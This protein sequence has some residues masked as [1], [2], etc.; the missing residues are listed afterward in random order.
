MSRVRRRESAPLQLFTKRRSTTESAYRESLARFTRFRE[1]ERIHRLSMGANEVAAYHSISNEPH[2][3]SGES[4]TPTDQRHMHYVPST[5]PP[6]PYHTQDISGN[7]NGMPHHDGHR[8]K[9][10]SVQFH[11]NG[12]SD[13]SDLNINYGKSRHSIATYGHRNA[14][15]SADSRTIHEEEIEQFE[16]AH[17]MYS[18]SAN[19]SDEQTGYHSPP[20]KF[21]KQN[22]DPYPSTSEA[23]SLGTLC[24]P[25]PPLRGKCPE[26][27]K[28]L[29]L[30]SKQSRKMLTE[31]HFTGAYRNFEIQSPYYSDSSSV[32][33]RND[34][35][36]NHE[37]INA[38]NFDRQRYQVIA[39]QN[40]DEVEYALPCT[41]DLPVFQRGQTLPNCFTSDDSILA[42]EIF[43]E[44]PQECE[45]ILNENI[46]VT[47]NASFS[48][49][50]RVNA[51]YRDH[52]GSGHIMIT[53]LDISTNT[54]NSQI[55]LTMCSNESAHEKSSYIRTPNRIKHFQKAMKRVD[56]IVCSISD[57]KSMEKMEAKLET[58]LHF[59]WGTFRRTNVT[60]RKYDNGGNNDLRL[61]TEA[62]MI[63]DAE[64]LR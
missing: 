8:I 58:P 4:T 48:M 38:N 26:K 57:F 23:S 61:I 28:R 19:A 39:N 35:Q 6:R 47:S 53:D 54:A 52:R 32:V 5:C 15:H 9:K 1:N 43:N 59:E 49:H 37:Q 55:D 46:E 30:N 36:P 34:Q 14:H 16:E 64:A 25:E 3:F 41:A 24:A 42:G 7:R 12:S 13:D 27:P 60:V 40:G 22:L 45:R 63:R 62:A 33:S 44:N 31:A 29:M 50:E 51:E 10:I 56:I 18:V 20:L 11:L 2:S 21:Y 17:C